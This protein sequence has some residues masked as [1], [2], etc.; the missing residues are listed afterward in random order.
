MGSGPHPFPDAQLVGVVGLVFVAEVLDE[1]AGDA[2]EQAADG[3]R[4]PEESNQA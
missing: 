1:Q 4:K 3:P 2:A